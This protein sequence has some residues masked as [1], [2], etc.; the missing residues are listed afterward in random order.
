MVYTSTYTYIQCTD[1]VRTGMYVVHNHT[2]LPIRPNQPCDTCESQLCTAAAPPEQPPSCHQSFQLTVHAYM[3]MVYTM[4]KHIIYMYVNV[5]DMYV[6]VCIMYLQY[7]WIHSRQN[8]TN[9]LDCVCQPLSMT[10][11]DG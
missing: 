10:S 2:S 5:Y 9:I 1:P 11:I 8:I 6:H 7:L 4:Y 3:N